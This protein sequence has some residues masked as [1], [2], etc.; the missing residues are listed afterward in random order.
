[1]KKGVTV[2]LCTFNGALRLRKTVQH[3]AVQVTKQKLDWELI[4]V[5]NASTDN[6]S[7]VVADEWQKYD[8]KHVPITM[9]KERK[10]GKIYALEQAFSK[11]KFEYGVICDDDNWLSSEYLATIY[12]IL[13]NDPAIGAVGGQGIAITDNGHLPD[14]FKE[15]E[16]GYAVGTQ[17][18]ESGD[19]TERGHLWG[20][21]LGTRTAL[22]RKMYEGFPSLL[23]GRLGQ[24]LTAG[25]DAEYCQRLVLA[26]YKLFYDSRLIFHHYMPE[27]RLTVHYRD[28]LFRGFIE[29]DRILSKY[30]IANELKNEAKKNPVNFLRLLVITPLRAILAANK[31]KRDQAKNILVFISPV[32]IYSNSII[33]RIKRFY[34]KNAGLPGS[35]V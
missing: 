10:A 14:W 15:Y 19:V 16:E 7:Q 31:K 32:S 12:N 5:D 17:S 35:L 18:D 25:E 21:G 29:S 1:M 11:A 30:Y 23:T 27:S 4:F 34:K 3:I 13:E 6:S 8:L 26:G 24:K 22:Y 28:R 9:L 2:I 20:A 33:S